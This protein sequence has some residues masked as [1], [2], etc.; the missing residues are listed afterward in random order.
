MAE[1][2]IIV[3]AEDKERAVSTLDCEPRVDFVR[4]SVRYSRYIKAAWEGEEDIH[5]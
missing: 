1:M 2:Q 4:L 3:V 5:V